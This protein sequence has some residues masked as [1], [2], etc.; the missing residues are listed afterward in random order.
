MRLM[1]NVFA[2]MLL[3]FSLSTLCQV[4]PDT[5]DAVLQHVRNAQ[6]YLSQQR[7]DLAI[8]EFESALTLDP[9]NLDAQA[10]LGVL[11]YFKGDFAKAVPYLHAA[12]K[13]KPDLWKIQAL[14]GLAEDHLKDPTNSRADLESALPHLK[15]EKVQMEV[16]NALIQSY[17]A[18]NDLEKA[19]HIVSVML[20]SQPTDAALLLMSYRLHSDLANASLLTLAMAAPQSAQMHQAMARELTRHGDE[21]AAVANYREAIKIDPKLPGLH[22]QLGSLLYNST[23]EKLQSEAE[24]QFQ[25]A[26]A[27]NPQDEKAQLMLGEIAVRQGNMKAAYDADARAAE[28]QPNDPDACSNLAQILMSMNQQQKAR[29]LLEHALAI[30]P[31]NYT[32][33][34]RLFSLDRQQGMPD[35]AKRELAEYKKYKELKDKLQSLFHDMRL[36]LDDKP[37]D[38][39]AVS[40]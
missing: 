17:T 14:L 37:E 23:D 29:T 27:A 15:G 3:A 38:T 1:P 12:V 40:N 19:V 10:N 6:Q 33:H 36:Q 7:P 8:P 11:L 5:N 25:A 35:D 2:L 21:A 32:A 24:A 13:T 30:D 31:T 18:D 39:G 26:L 28:M 20:E 16:G 34:Y 9:T 22:F 4:A